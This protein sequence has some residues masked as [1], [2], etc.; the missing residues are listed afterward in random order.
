MPAT[1]GRNASTD[2]THLQHFPDGKPAA[3]RQRGGEAPQDLKPA[4][5]PVGLD[6]DTVTGW[7]RQATSEA[8]Q[9]DVTHHDQHLSAGSTP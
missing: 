8:V 4:L 1:G 9:N 2:Q 3:E 6:G 7:T 5:R